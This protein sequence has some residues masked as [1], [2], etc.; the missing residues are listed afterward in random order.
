MIP[1]RDQ[2]TLLQA[3]YEL[4]KSFPTIRLLMIG[5]GPGRADLETNAKKLGLEGSVNFIGNS[6]EIG[7]YLQAADIY[8]NPTLDEGFGI[9]VV[10]A[11]HSG[12]PVVLSD[13]GAHP[14][15]IIPDH[16]GFLY[17]GGDSDALASRLR[18]LIEDPALMW[19]VGDA[20]RRH[21]QQHFSP[22][23][24]STQY[25]KSVWAKANFSCRH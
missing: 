2:L 4:R 23:S 15:L 20:G 12:I 18:L 8:V 17:P 9:A 7:D 3:V 11:M 21:A 19:R 24:Y 6:A 16:T 13:R 10:E 14:E 22:H 25:L 1:E 5:D